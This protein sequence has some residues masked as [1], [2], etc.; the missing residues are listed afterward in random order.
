MPEQQRRCQVEAGR[1]GAG[2]R[3]VPGGVPGARGGRMSVGGA[4]GDAGRQFWVPWGYRISWP[5][6]RQISSAKVLV[7]AAVHVLPAPS[8]PKDQIV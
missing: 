7:R 3:A 6:E 2:Y 8:L 1:K 4:A 5:L